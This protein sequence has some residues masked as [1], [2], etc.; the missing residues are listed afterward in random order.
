M[1]TRTKQ[2]PVRVRNYIRIRN[3]QVEFVDAHWRSYPK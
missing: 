2:K 1:S 3:G